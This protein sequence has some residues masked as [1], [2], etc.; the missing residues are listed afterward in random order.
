MW[1]IILAASLGIVSVFGE[2]PKLPYVSL[3]LSD[4][5]SF[6]FEKILVISDVHGDD[7][8]LFQSLWLSLRKLNETEHISFEDFLLHVDSAMTGEDVIPLYRGQDVL[9]VQMGDLLD[10]GPNG[11]GCVDIINAV[12]SAIGWTTRIL[13][14]NHDM[15]ALMG[16]SYWDMVHVD[17]DIDRIKEFGITAVGELKNW[18]LDNGLL[19]VRVKDHALFVHG[20][21]ELEWLFEHMPFETKDRV[22]I[23]RINGHIRNSLLEMT[24][25]MVHALTNFDSPVMSRKIF[26]INDQNTACTEVDRVLDFF[27]VK[28]IVVGHTPQIERR[29]TSRCHNKIIFSDA[30]M[31]RW[32]INPEQ[33]IE[34]LD[35]TQP[36]ALIMDL[37]GDIRAFY[38]IGIDDPEIF[39]QSIFDID[40]AKDSEDKENDITSS[41]VKSKSPGMLPIIFQDNFVTI[42]RH[43]STGFF[44][45]PTDPEQMRILEYI[46]AEMVEEDDKPHPGLPVIVLGHHV[47]ALGIQRSHPLI[48]KPDEAVVAVTRLFHSYSLCVGFVPKPEDST[49]V[50]TRPNLWIHSFFNEEHYV[51]INLSRVR[52]CLDRNELEV[53]LLFINTILGSQDLAQSSFSADDSQTSIQDHSFPRP[54]THDGKIGYLENLPHGILF[55][56]I[57]SMVNTGHYGMPSSVAR[58]PETALFVVSEESIALTNTNCDSKLAYQIIGIIDFLHYRNIRLGIDDMRQDELDHVLSFFR[59]DDTDKNAVRLIDFSQME[60]CQDKKMLASERAYVT[61]ALEPFLEDSEDDK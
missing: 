45:K 42:M 9:L 15:Y 40:Q 17:D 50:K 58:V 35:G 12:P 18:Y 28:H 5:E 52:R 59:A 2:I 29:M 61:Y 51:I 55:E 41:L 37:S 1:N 38:S 49:L 26:S 7:L 13:Y 23:D 4:F 20:G 25:S 53:E 27:N 3:P 22:C 48:E 31:S 39:E 10:R 33:D 36:G 32:M 47:V 19:A 11:R 34:D 30:M 44:L 54:A 14:G 60:K 56:D 43:S 57:Q 8:A 46:Q 21:M 6:Q 16:H 24:Q